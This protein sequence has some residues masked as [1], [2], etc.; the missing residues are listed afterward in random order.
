MEEV[1][2]PTTTVEDPKI[3][4]I[5]KSVLDLQTMYTED[6]RQHSFNAL[7]CGETGAGKTYLARTARF[8]VHIDSFDPGGTQGLRKEIAAKDIIVD[9]RYENEDPLAPNAY[10]L[11]KANFLQRVRDGYFNH[12]GTYVLDSS[13]M[14][15]VTIMN[16]ILAADKRPGTGPKWEKDFGPQKVEIKN[17]IAIMTSLPCDFLL[18]G[19]LK[20]DKD[21]VTGK[22]TYRFMSV[23]DSS[24]TIPMAF[25]E[26]YVALAES[27]GAVVERKLLTQKDSFYLA[28]TRV[29]AGKFE[30]WEEPNI[31]AMLKKAGFPCEDKPNIFK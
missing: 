22:T 10:R 29:G 26:I 21:E 19:H 11:W 16:W 24:V 17:M 15:S 2:V 31:K 7:I 25:S 8:P 3:L 4:A 12:F 13:S 14:W 28:R 20:A 27:K 5:K 18:M 9:S 30:R 1:P 6:A 23:G